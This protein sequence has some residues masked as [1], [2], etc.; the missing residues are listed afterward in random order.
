MLTVLI[1]STLTALT[2]NIILAS[3]PISLGLTILLITLLLALFYAT[4]LSSWIALLIF[5]LYAGGILVIFSYFVAITPNQHLFN[6]TYITLII[7]MTITLIAIITNTISPI[8][9]Q[10]H[11]IT[12]TLYV[13][14]NTTI[15]LI[16]ALLLLLTILIV[17]KISSHTQG[18]LR[19]FIS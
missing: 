9:L 14:N 10:N 5:L 19:P 13:S 7:T 15:L 1:T 18:P 16:L 2:T 3:R 12:T 4:T 6:N 17:V 11:P 8:A